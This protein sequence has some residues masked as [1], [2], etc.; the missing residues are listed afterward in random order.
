MSRGKT[1]EELVTALRAET[2]Y[3][4]SSS[5]SVAQ[6]PTLQY[7]IR[8]AYE[9]LHDEY[10][11][12]FLNVRADKALAAGQRYYDVPTTLAYETI[13]KIEVLWNGVWLPVEAGISMDDYTIYDSDSDERVDPVLKWGVLDTGSGEQIEVWPIPATAGT[14]RFH[15]TRKYATLVADSDVADLD[16]TAI[17]LKAAGNILYPKDREAARAKFQQMERRINML[18][19]RAAPK[20]GAPLVPGGAPRRQPFGNFNVRVARSN[21]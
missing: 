13:E 21:S 17:A 10:E 14:L 6:L 16:G 4:T 11:W 12:P 15:G 2:G 20:G 19:V 9:E 3:N 7:H 8:R 5:A 18:K 1:L